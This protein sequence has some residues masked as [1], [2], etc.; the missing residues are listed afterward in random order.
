VGCFVLVTDIAFPHSILHTEDCT[1]PLFRS[2]NLSSLWTSISSSTP[3]PTLVTV[4]PPWLRVQLFSGR[5]DWRGSIDTVR[6]RF[7][8]CGRERCHIL[9]H[10]EPRSSSVATECSSAT[11]QARSQGSFDKPWEVSLSVLLRQRI[12]V[13]ARNV[14]GGLYLGRRCSVSKGQSITFFRP[15]AASSKTRYPRAVSWAR[16][17]LLTHSLGS[18]TSRDQWLRAQAAGGKSISAL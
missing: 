3:I 18:V 12:A 9:F 13:P 14:V 6:S 5:F 10:N 16:G 1:N 2:S 7:G 15:T 17:R 8:L 4:P 11:P